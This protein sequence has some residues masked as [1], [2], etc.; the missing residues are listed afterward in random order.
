[1]K[2]L[3]SLIAIIFASL[4]IYAQDSYIDFYGLKI[5]KT[6]F[7]GIPIDGSKQAVQSALIAKGYRLSDD[8]NYLTGR[9]NGEDVMVLIHTENGKVDRISVIDRHNRS[10]TDIKIRFNRLCSQFKDNGKYI[11]FDDFTISEDEDISYEM[12]VHNKRY[13]A[14]F[15]QVGRN[16]L[17]DL[18]EEQIE[19]IGIKYYE[20]NPI[21]DEDR[22]KLTDE[23][24]KTKFATG[25]TIEL[26]DAVSN[27]NVWFMINESHGEY[28]IAMYYDNESNRA[29]GED[30]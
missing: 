7:L 24:L 9:F 15:Y 26:F 12:N 10:E 17:S 1:M 20:R 11:S 25:F 18:T 19:T 23:E 21:S 3:I 13:E 27:N 4:T 8:G 5:E 28:Y 6:K 16:I 22:E 30:L 14:A 2:K 29:N